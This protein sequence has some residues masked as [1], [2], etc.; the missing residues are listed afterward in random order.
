MNSIISYR[1]PHS[2]N[3]K[4]FACLIFFQADLN[5]EASLIINYASSPLFPQFCG[6]AFFM[7]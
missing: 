5:I 4:D 3:K 2:N 1:S 6:T 7:Q